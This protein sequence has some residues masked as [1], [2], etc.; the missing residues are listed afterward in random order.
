MRRVVG[1]LVAVASLVLVTSAQAA[2]TT[3]AITSPSD[4]Y[5][6]LDRG[7]GQ[8]ITIAGT[9]NGTS[10]DQVDI[11]CYQ[12]DGSTAARESTVASGVP[13]QSGGSFSTSA[14]IS[15]LDDRYPHHA[16]CRL[17]AVPSGSV[18]TSGLSS[19]S[20]PRTAVAYLEQYAASSGLY[21]Y[22]FF[23]PQLAG[24]SDPNS[25]GNC[26]LDDSYL[27]DPTVFG[28]QDMAGFYCNDYVSMMA[29][30][31]STRPGLEVDGHPAYAP[32]MEN[33]SNLGF[34]PMTIDSITRNSTNGDTTLVETEPI[35]RCI[36]DAAYNNNC[37]SYVSAGVQIKRT[38]T[39]NDNGHIQYFRDAWS[40]TDGAAHDVNLLLE[41][42]QYFDNSSNLEYQF[43]GQTAFSSYGTGQ[44]VSVPTKA[45][46]SILVQNA[47]QPDGSTSG[48][49]GA[50]TY[51]QSPSGSFA[52]SN[53]Q[54]FDAPNVVSVP[55]S[56]SKTIG[57]AYS[58][59]YTLAAAAHDA[60]V[61]QDAFLPPA[62]TIAKPK[63]HSKV[64]TS[65]VTVSGT[66]Q[67][68]SGVKSVTVNGR[69][70]TVSGGKFSTTVRLHPGKNRLIV[71]LT[72]AAGKTVTKT[73]TVTRVV[74]AA[75]KKKTTAK[76]KT[77]PTFT[78]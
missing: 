7:T 13:V 14:P 25:F 9:S 1:L 38:F 35:V 22:Y 30:S 36:T 44:S 6:G 58:T 8:T 46:A 17:R 31:N 51:A 68:G 52:F 72:S 55:A 50:I 66:A 56:G 67:A 4:P 19:F 77:G 69:K 11:L 32:D 10:G 23:D 18:P 78:G 54:V 57:Y 26:G 27:W 47:A 62:V 75:A 42:D 15:S 40:S 49:R 61:A 60:L 34:Q 5:F 37:P 20:G 12:D 29:A 65:K 76:K 41:N 73:V 43:P 21:D 59:E 33:A 64:K 63:N 48:G 74:K 24:G 16:P 53:S 71:K 45:P 3:S 39:Q 70:V 28:Q 2:V